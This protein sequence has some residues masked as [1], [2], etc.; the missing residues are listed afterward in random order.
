MLEKVVKLRIIF[1]RFTQNE[2]VQS[3]EMRSQPGANDA[4][5]AFVVAAVT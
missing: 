4:E 3:N 1:C 5:L 2:I